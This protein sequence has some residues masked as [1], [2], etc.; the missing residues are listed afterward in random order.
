VKPLRVLIVAPWGEREGGA[1][2]M[3]WSLLRHVDRSRIEPEVVFLSPGPLVTDVAALGIA[4]QTLPSGRLRDPVTYVRTVAKLAGRLRRTQPDVVVAWSAKAHLYLGMANLFR[5]RRRPAV[6][7]QHAIP[8]GHWIDRAATLVPA[9]AIGCSSQA[10][11]AAQSRALP[12]RRT[13]VVYPGVEIDPV[14]QAVARADLGISEDA[15]VVGSVGRLQPWKGHDRVISAVADLRRR[16]IP[17]VGLIVG[18]E[19]FGLSP[20]YATRLAD[21]AREL[22][23]IEN[24]VFTGQVGRAD[25]YLGAMNV[26][27]NAS[28]G[29][30]F[31]IAL[32]EAMA[33]RRPV[34]AFAQG[35]P[36]EIIED[37]VSGLLTDRHELV[38][39]LERLARD[40]PLA[41]ALADG[42]AARAA[43]FS[44]DRA[45][46]EFR[47]A[48][49]ELVS[50]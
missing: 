50:D 16:A 33:A 22:G 15:W 44:A 3:L 2:Q 27:V 49:G 6:W 40:E 34:V 4:A 24:V 1:E 7:W 10:S 8:A 47:D 38:D 19:A 35:G 31:G 25:S 5:E 11:A 23:V 48:L 43:A 41:R 30:P 45:A 14:R 37:G 21:R 26:F 29:E 46:A 12:R 20:G 32:V 17:A 42:G 36:T 28:D 13:F 39:T 9:A 18:G